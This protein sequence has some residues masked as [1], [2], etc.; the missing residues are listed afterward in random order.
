MTIKNAF[1]LK[2]HVYLI[3]DT[4]QLERIVVGI[5]VTPGG[6]L[7]YTLTCGGE[8]SEHYDF[9]ISAEFDT[10]KKVSN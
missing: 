2:E 10:L 9:E 7:T 5:Y 3:T 6:T 8:E 1:E 4:E